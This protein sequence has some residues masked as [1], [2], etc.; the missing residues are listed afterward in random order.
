VSFFTDF[1]GNSLNIDGLIVNLSGGTIS[2]LS[3]GTTP[4]LTNQIGVHVYATGIVATNFAQHLSS[5][6]VTMY[7]GNGSWVFETSI[8]ILQLSTA[9]ERFRTIH[10]FA[11][12][13]AQ[14]TETDGVFFTYEEGGVFN[15]TAASPNWQCV[16]VANS[17]RTLTTTSTAVSASAW[18]K[19][20]IEI[21]AAGTS[22]AFYVNGTLVATHTTNIPLGSNSRY[23]NVKQGLYKAT[24]LTSRA[25]Y[26][27]YLGYENIQT[28]PR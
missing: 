2:T 17:V 19:L 3:I 8:N 4:Q 27:D 7:L 18:N 6:A 16:T 9:L 12:F 23:L 13:V 26:V 21:N 15:G 11:T 1:F 14:G 5:G 24:G 10:G 20:R 28:T 25:M 22:V